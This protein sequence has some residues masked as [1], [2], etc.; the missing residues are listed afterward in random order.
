MITAW[1]FIGLNLI[2]SVSLY[3]Y[4]GRK[5]TQPIQSYIEEPIDFNK[6]PKTK[7][8]IE[9]KQQLENVIEKEIQE[10]ELQL[11]VLVVTDILNSNSQIIVLGEECNSVE[12]AFEKTL[13]NNMMFLEGVVSRK[14]QILPVIDKN[15]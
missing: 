11:F 4:F 12:K 5:E 2:I 15:I 9:R 8:E 13:E 7:K 6:K 14:K 10:N 1:T 3:N